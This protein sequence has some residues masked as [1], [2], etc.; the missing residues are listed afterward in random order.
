MKIITHIDLNAFFAQCEENINPQLK[1]YPIAIGK[2]EKRQVCSTCNYKAREYGVRSAMPIYQAKKICP[3]LVIIEP[4]FQLYSLISTKFMNF[5]KSKF[6]IMEIAS[7][8]ETYIDITKYTSVDKVYDFLYDLQL[9]IYSK[10]S[11]KC[12]IGCSY[13]KF[14]A[15]MA[16]DY[17]KPMGLTL[18]FND[19][20]KKLFWD[21]DI[22]KMWGIGSKTAPK[23]KALGINTIKDLALTNSLEV[24]S[25]LG[26]SYLTFKNWANGIGND[27]LDT[28]LSDPKSISCSITLKDN[29][30][31]STFLLDT[32]K[33]LVSQIVSNLKSKDQL[34]DKIVLI[35]RDKDFKT[36][37]KHMQIDASD[38]I[39]YIQVQF[40][41]LFSKFYKG[42]LIR[43]I[44]AGLEVYKQDYNEKQ[45]TLLNE[46][47]NETDDLI[48]KLNNQFDDKIKLKKLS[49]LKKK[50]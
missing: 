19:D 17:K 28:S 12:S 38:D 20:Y 35:L 2:D 46:E 49:D 9:E 33:Q 7:I 18:V 45:L 24:S 14:L 34:T 31:D 4:H 3:N 5:L 50:E 26:S 47:N 13:N 10:L 41:I 21:L 30:D 15:K 39:E 11:L 27:I 6:D 48:T 1:N 40:Q 44:G 36:T 43:L 25:L 22:S 8:D 23:L 42:Q 32:L 29:S 16:S 37:S